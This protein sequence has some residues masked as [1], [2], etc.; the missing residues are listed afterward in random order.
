MGSANKTK[1]LQLPQWL[2]NEYFER[3]DMN[4]AF[5]NIEKAVV[6]FDYIISH[7]GYSFQTTRGGGV[8]TI[9][10]TAGETCPIT[11]QLVAK[12]G[13]NNNGQTTIDIQTTIDQTVTNEHHELG[14]DNGKGGP[15]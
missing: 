8:T 5:S 3:L 1:A 13:R 12:I 10:V 4:G 11:A 2:G 9:T 7:Y 6:T 14:R 15:R